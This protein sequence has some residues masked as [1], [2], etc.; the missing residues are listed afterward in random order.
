[1][2]S[3]PFLINSSASSNVK[4]SLNNVFCFI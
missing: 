4:S 3:A 1:L 2:T